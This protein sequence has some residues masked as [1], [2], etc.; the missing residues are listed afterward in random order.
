[1][2]EEIQKT[3]RDLRHELMERISPQDLQVCLR[4]LTE[5]RNR[6]SEL[7]IPKEANGSNGIKQNG[8]PGT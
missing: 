6:A 3:A 4:V 7:D 1:L 2:L 8:T 5:I